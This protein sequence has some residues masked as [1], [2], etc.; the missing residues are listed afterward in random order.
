M[1]KQISCIIVDDERPAREALTNYIVEYCSW[2][3][4]VEQCDSVKSAYK[5]ISNLSPDLIFL[6][7]EMPNGNGFELLRMFNPIPFRVVFV[8]A[9]SQYAVDA[10]RFAAVDYLMKP[11]KVAELVNAVKKVERELRDDRSLGELLNLLEGSLLNHVQNRQ[12]VIADT[13]GFSVV[14]TNDII[15]LEADGYCTKL[16]LAGQTPIVSTRNLKYFEEL[17]ND[18]IFL[19]VHHSNIINLDHVKG[20]SFQEEIILSNN[21]RCPLSRVH[22]KHFMDHYKPKKV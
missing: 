16:F 20:Y 10:F 19:R 12:L 11:I 9:F 15:L 13:K 2:L 14:R 8:T 6:D 7:I 22:K 4:I 3:S 1:D 5:A 17:L 18:R 21:H